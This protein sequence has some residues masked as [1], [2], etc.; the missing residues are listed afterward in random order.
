MA[1]ATATRPVSNGFASF[2][3]RRKRLGQYFTGLPLARLLAALADAAHADSVIDPMAGTG[4]M[5]AGALEYGE[6][7]L[8][9]GI[10]I[11]PLAFDACAA[12]L[13][14]EPALVLGNAFAPDTI[15]R[16]PR[17][18]WDLVIANPPYVRY[19]S[20]ARAIGGDLRVPSGAEVRADLLASLALLDALD[21]E[22]RRLF[23]ELARGYSGL[24]DLA[25]PAWL[26]CAGLVRKG[27]T[28]ALVVP[29]AW[30]SR[31]YAQPIRLLLERWFDV[32][33]VVEDVDAR[34]F[35]DALVR[36]TLVVAT[37]I[38]RRDAGDTGDRAGHLHVAL[39][40]AC[41]DDR[42]VVGALLPD[43]AS[44][45]LEFAAAVRRWSAAPKSAPSGDG[46]AARWVPP[47]G[48]ESGL[49]EGIVEALGCSPSGLVTLDD[50][51]WRAGQGLRTG[52]N[53][54]FH[55]RAGPEDGALL[56]SPKLGGEAIAAP[57]DAVLPVL[58]RQA[59]LPDGYAVHADRIEGR[60]LMLDRYALA[61]DLEGLAIPPY[62][63]MPSELAAHVRRAARTDVGTADTP[64]LISELSSVATNARAGDAGRAPRFWYQLPAFTDRHRPSLLVARVNGGHPR[65]L[66]NVDRAAL[67]D[68]NFSTLWP[69]RD[70]SVDAAALL[71]LLN[72]SWC[73][74]ILESAGTVLGGGALKV[75]ATH[76]RQMPIPPLSEDAWAKLSALGSRLAAGNGEAAATLGAI[77]RLVVD[78]IDGLDDVAAA[79]ERVDAVAEQLLRIRSR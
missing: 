34:W 9:G 72:S 67:I 11:D 42:S 43:A 45:E 46:I 10:E 59:D 27:G 50:L 21:D 47:A 7:R 38:E 77:D 18:V 13:G 49:P 71:A 16:L 41:A 61:E 63:P 30:L 31:D 14:P 35:P 54:F 51:G 60:V 15:A 58:Q 37:R 74:A 6:P 78:S 39:G 57:A 36:T 55:L 17:R 44:P 5:L 23:G 25:V 48:G 73:T 33:C 40:A 68:A 76:L 69:T 32:R 65:T 22:D 20:G 19:Q 62:E 56:P 70:S 28:L 4:D 53:S 3:E 26:L 29:A 12:R 24:A 66:V 2:G 64:K 79:C 52:A 1:P 75:E 8:V